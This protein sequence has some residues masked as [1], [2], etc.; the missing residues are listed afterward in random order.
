MRTQTKE[1]FRMR[2]LIWVM[3]AGLAYIEILLSILLIT[4]MLVPARETRIL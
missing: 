2:Q 1:I 4:I 3:L